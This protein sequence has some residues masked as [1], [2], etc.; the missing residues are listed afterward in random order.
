MA[1]YISYSKAQ[2]IWN[3]FLDYE[4]QRSEWALN[5]ANCEDFFYG[6]QWTDRELKII[7]DRGMAPLVI[8]R[9]MP[10]IQQEMTIFLSKRPT[11][12]PFPAGDGDVKTAAV[13]GDAIQHV[14][15][16]SQGDNQY[17]ITMN[18][19]FVLGAGY[20][21]AYI[22]PYADEG[23]GE[24]MIKSTPPWDVY[25]DP[26]S[27]EIDLSD[28]Q[29]IL[30]SRRISREQLLMMYPNKDGVINKAEIEEGS[31]IDRPEAQS[32]TNMNSSIVNINYVAH[33]SEG[34]IRVTE[35]YEKVKKSYWKVMD[36]M[37]GSIHRYEKLP[38]EYKNVVKNKNSRIRAI[39][40]YEKRVKVT[41]TAGAN[42]VIDEYELRTPIYPIV[43]FFLHHRRN[44]YPM[45]DVDAIKGLQ[46]EVNKRRSIMI[47][48][49]TLSGNY[50]FLAEKN[51]ITNKEEFQKKGSQ[52]GFIL[53]YQATGGEPPR[54]LLPQ[55]LPP[56][57]IQLE[58]EAKADM[59]YTLS[60]FAHMMGSNQDAPETY[61]GLLALEERGQQKIQYKA[62]HAKQGL[63]NLGLVV[64]HLIQQTYSPQKMLRVVG[65]DNE[66]VREVFANEMQIDPLTGEPKTLNDLTIGNYDLIIVDGT[67]MPSNRMALL[68]LYLEMYQLGIIDKQEVLKKTDIVDREGVLERTGEVQQAQQQSAQ[69]EE[70]LKNEQGLN[71]TLRRALQQTEVQMGSQKYL[72]GMEREAIKTVATEDLKRK[73]MGD[74]LQMM[75]ER[76]KLMER[77]AKSA[78]GA[79]VEKVGGKLALIQM[80]AELEADLE[81]KRA[82]QSQSS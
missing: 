59:E 16:I 38:K 17:Q 20:M 33:D 65:E 56:A 50:R 31:N 64:M 75:R 32:S 52:P 61:R 4:S 73:R 1:S 29:Y 13:F 43:P 24:V 47:H 22:D 41:V 54:E 71:Q 34:K 53:E 69:L 79:L 3:T 66:E 18:D 78:S 6:K 81:R 80:R 44:P 39:K 21:L 82:K 5:A 68:N 55:P 37:T 62:A 58:G 30:I 15:H 63:R 76:I 51:T 28:A 36:A 35:C 23:R 9:T 57:F 12:R 25:A 11:F 72:V 77:E 49:A 14:W 42:T 8:N 10:I 7:Q 45:G 27:R 19:F 60:V 74:E 46:Q 2:R 67:S 48:N 40:I 70:A 26:N